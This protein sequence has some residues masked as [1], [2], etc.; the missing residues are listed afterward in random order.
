MKRIVRIGRALLLGGLLTELNGQITLIRDSI[1]MGAGYAK[2]VYYS[3]QNGIVDTAPAAGWHLAFEIPI[4]GAAIRANTAREVIIYRTNRDTSGWNVLSLS[5]TLERLYDDLCRWEKGALNQTAAPNNPFDV[6]W[7][8]YNLTTHITTGD[9]LYII[10]LPGGMYKKLWIQRLE[11]TSYYVRVANLDGSEDTVYQVQ[12]TQASGRNFVY[13]NLVTKQVLN[14][15]PLSTSWDI[16]FT[17]YTAFIPPAGTPYPVIGVLQN[18]GVK[19]TRIPLPRTAN[20]DTL[21]IGA[22]PLDSC[23]SRVGYDWKRFDMTT[24]SWVLADTVYYLVQDKSRNIWRLRFV[25][26]TGSS[27]GKAIFEKALLQNASLLH[28]PTF[29][30]EIKI[31]PQPAQTGFFILLPHPEEVEICLYTLQGQLLYYSKE[32]AQE[33]FFVARPT[34]ASEGLYILQISSKAGLWRSKVIFE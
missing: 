8:T 24:N 2:Q 25:G 22:Y 31:F 29:G 26:F 14:L 12:K 15:E 18:I 1:Q 30:K 21:T 23:I 3:L 33:T 4:R 6:G 34:M 32:S 27:T 7:G 19:A 9:S 28:A 11:G 20:P 10:R 16:V 13:L 17:P 5:D